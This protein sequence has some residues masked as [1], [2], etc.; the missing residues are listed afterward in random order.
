[1]RPIGLLLLIGC[2]RPPDCGPG[3]IADGDVCAPEACGEGDWGG[4]DEQGGVTVGPNGDYASIQSAVDAATGGRVVIAAGTYREN[5]TL[6]DGTELLGRCAGLVVLDG[7]GADEPTVSAGAGSVG[8]SGVTITGG[9]H[10]VDVAGGTLTADGL[11]VTGNRHVGLDAE[12]GGALIVRSSTVRDNVPG[13]DGGGYGITAWA[14][15]A[16]ISDSEIVGNTQVG[17]LVSEIGGTADLVNTDIVGTLPTGESSGAGVFAQNG[18]AVTVSG[19]EIR[20]NVG[21]GVVS[22]LTETFV[23]LL[24]V[25]VADTTADQPSAGRGIIAVEGG[26]ISATSCTL[27]G[28]VESGGAALGPGAT[29]DVADTLITG[30]LAPASEN[31]A[32]GLS[33]FDGA[34]LTVRGSTIEGTEGH[35]IYVED[36][37]ATL[38]DTVIRD[39]VVVE[40]G[41]GG[42]V[43]AMAGAMVQMQGCTV[44]RSK[45]A[46]VQ[47]G[48]AGASL[49]I[50]DSWIGETGSGTYFDGE[51]DTYGVALLVLDGGIA[52]VTGSTITDNEYAAIA[53]AAGAVEVTSTRIDFT[54]PRADGVGGAALIV[55]EGGT[56]SCVDCGLE[57]NSPLGAY[58][59]GDGSLLQLTDVQVTGTVRSRHA[60]MAMGAVAEQAAT[61]EAVRLTVQDTAGLGLYSATGTL[62]CED[63]TLVDNAFAGAAVVGGGRMELTG[64]TITGTGPDDEYGGGVG[65]YASDLI[66][67]STLSLFDSTIGSHPYA[68]AWLDGNGA[69]DLERNT[70]S[71]GPGVRS[72]ANLL[73]GNAVFAERGVTAWQGTSG[74]NLVG[75]T[76]VDTPDVAVFLHGAAATLDGNTWSGGGVSVRQQLCQTAGDVAGGDLLDLPD[77]QLCPDENELVAYDFRLRTLYLATVGTAE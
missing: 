14:A 11:L 44:E 24:D 49:N 76:F 52:T 66:A 6:S 46:G 28:N 31:V 55:T 22:Y 47:C 63:C 57:G 16:A 12:E 45:G 17:V 13:D 4:L 73:H 71:G 48:G 33:A 15:S 18:G 26:T 34:V 19:G 59:S 35:G 36:S 65:V 50:S 62:I 9:N 58:A 43:L 21:F 69:Y 29:L 74:L 3:E 39:S 2:Q 30:T 70:L 61:I 64:A 67:A 38:T 41:G 32:N 42:G 51:P 20:G 8:L 75:N 54:R 56:L 27:A 23:T 72:G 77:A 5:V 60:G 10:G 7:S 53:A 25:T 40:A 68:A 1:M 37:T